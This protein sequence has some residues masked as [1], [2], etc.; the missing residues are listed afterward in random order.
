[1][2]KWWYKILNY[3][4]ITKSNRSQNALIWFSKM[5]D[6]N[7]RMTLLHHR[8]PTYLNFLIGPK[9]MYHVDYKWLIVHTTEGFRHLW[10]TAWR[11]I[12]FRPATCTCLNTNF[13][14]QQWTRYRKKIGLL[15][16][17]FIEMSHRHDVATFLAE[18]FNK[19]RYSHISKFVS[20]VHFY[21]N[22]HLAVYCNC[23]LNI[24]TRIIKWCKIFCVLYFLTQTL[25][26]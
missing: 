25:I 9:F 10:Y 20:D 17:C 22:T 16:I 2:D 18:Q 6:N 5:V 26:L 21:I 12:T 4:D 24:F 1:M 8:L 23:E 11:D 15:Y 19:K 3:H 13:V 7:K 14:L